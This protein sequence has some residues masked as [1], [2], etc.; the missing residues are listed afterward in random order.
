MES[1]L[2]FITDGHPACDGRAQPDDE[3]V[4]INVGKIFV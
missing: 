3:P 1:R 2:V 4:K